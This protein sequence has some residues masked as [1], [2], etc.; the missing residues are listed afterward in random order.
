MGE[1][2][3]NLYY[4]LVFGAYHRL[5]LASGVSG[6]PCSLPWIQDLI[7]RC[8]A[9]FLGSV[10]WLLVM[11]LQFFGPLVLVLNRTFGSKALTWSTCTFPDF[12]DWEDIWSTKFLAM[13]VVFAFVINGI[14]VVE[15]DWVSWEKMNLIVFRLNLD[16]PNWSFLDTRKLWLLCASF[17]RCWVV[18]W[19]CIASFVVLGPGTTAEFVVLRSV[20]LLFLFKLDTAASAFSFVHMKA[21]PGSKIEWLY[22]RSALEAGPEEPKT[23]VGWLVICLYNCTLSFLWLLAVVLPLGICFISFSTITPDYY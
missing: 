4:M 11:F 13:V 1:A 19:T 20:T 12:T 8:K 2:A 17:M 3:G 15:Q 23:C 9:S 10:G 21:W 16:R 22:Q 5:P 14:F 7:L 18:C 6:D